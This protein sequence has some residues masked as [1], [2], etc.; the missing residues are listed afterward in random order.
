MY[1][2]VCMYFVQGFRKVD[3]DKWEFANEG[4]LK[5]QKHLL[6]N[7]RRRKTTA[8]SP[9]PHVLQTMIQGG[10]YQSSSSSSSSCVEVGMF[11][12]LDG[13][14]E[15]LRRDKQVLTVELVKLRQH[16]QHTKSYLNTM[17]QRL[18]GTEIKQQ[19]MMSFLAKALR[20]P[21]F[22]D[23]MVQKNEKRKKLEEAI[24]KKRRKPIAGVE[25]DQLLGLGGEINNSTFVKLE[26]QDYGFDLDHLDH[27]HGD[28]GILG[29]QTTQGMN[30]EGAGSDEGF[31]KGI[32]SEGI[33][34][35][36]E[37]GFLD[38][39][40]EDVDVEILAQQLDFLNS[41]LP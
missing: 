10:L 29:M 5:G 8:S 26:P 37:V 31:W 39:E 1:I 20:N 35:G 38:V 27:D 25:E 17:E 19:Q 41:K 21:S 4:F 16:Q 12:S 32:L 22:L 11:G 6:R 34:N 36:G 9:S 7:I 30:M 13:E 24:N 15:L 14:I 33:D 2:Y 28:G 3:P 18:K 23:Q 40:G